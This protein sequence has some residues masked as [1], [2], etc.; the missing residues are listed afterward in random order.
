M[1]IIQ[2]KI[3]NTIKRCKNETNKNCSFSNSV[4]FKSAPTT[5]IL[6]VAKGTLYTQADKKILDIFS[7]YYDDV[8]ERLGTKVYGLAK[9]SKILSKS[10]R[11]DISKGALS[12]KDK[13]IGRAFVESVVFPFITLP[14]Y[15]GSWVLKKVQS[16]PGL[17]TKARSIYNK[18][19]LRVPRKYNELDSKTDMIK[20]IFD[21]TQQVINKYAKEKGLSTETVL[22][23]LGDNP[24]DKK[25]AQE[26]RDYLRESLYKVSN[27]FF[28][29]RTGNYNTAHERS[30]N[31]IVSGLIPAAF[32]ANDAYNLSVLCGDKKEA[33]DKEAKDRKNQE[34]A[35]VLT[36]AYIQLV[37]FGAFVKQVNTK[38]WFVPLASALTVLG[39]EIFSRKK[40]KKPIFFLSKEKAK[41][42]N[43]KHNNIDA[44]SKSNNNKTSNKL[45]A[46]NT[47]SQIVKQENNVATKKL[48]KQ[49]EKNTIFSSFKSNPQN[50]KESKTDKSQTQI[51]KDEP[52]K[53]LLNFKTFKNAVLTCLATGF[54]VSFLKNSS[55]TKNSKLVQGVGNIG[56]FFKEKVYSPLAFKDFEIPQQKYNNVMGIL[57]QSNCEKISQGHDF[58]MHKYGAV[59]DK[60]GSDG[61]VNKVIKMFQG[62]LSKEKAKEISNLS[63]QQLKDFG[64]NLSDSDASKVMESILAAVSK[65]K[66]ALSEYKYDKVAQK[67]L[68]LISRKKVPLDSDTS[69]KFVENLVKSLENNVQK[70]AIKVDR[71]SKPFVDILT[72]PFKFV[73]SAVRLPYK[74]V[75]SLLRLSVSP[76]EKKLKVSTAGATGAKLT[77]LEKGFYRVVT[78]F[79]GTSK[80]KTGKNSQVVFASAMETLA[81]KLKPYLSKETLTKQDEQKI[82]AYVKIAVEKSFNGVTQSSNKNTELAMM[83]KLVSSA[84]TSGFLVADNYNMVMIKSNGE[85]K[86]GAK[87][88]ANERIVQRLSALFY[89]ALLINWFNGTFNS[90]YHSSLKGMASVVAPNTITTEVLTRKSIGMPIGKKSF[91]EIQE[92]E[93]KN[94]NRKGFLGKYFKFMRLLTG[95]KPLKDRLPKEK[96]QVNSSV[97]N[98]KFKK[99]NTTNLI[100]KFSK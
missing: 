43:R 83:A 100:E 65:E 23:L 52:K 67:A 91:E 2:P 85:D 22:D 30:L 64:V 56:K 36:T 21:K 97:G 15:F 61:S 5:E 45:N 86:E 8:A 24:K 79:I 63:I 31:R 3:N 17:K 47:N 13:N 20:G 32:L 6:N 1:N 60:V 70:T 4:S 39:S 94:E 74:I 33:S 44:N 71:K 68:S 59:V 12:I 34:I 76:I 19:I 78:E 80:E 89:Q 90:Q 27:K 53:A 40:V 62:V 25:M 75:S 9:E 98:A 55:F 95:K 66:V 7:N 46:N 92:I 73:F 81:K 82:A 49:N 35:R 16:I 51:K 54:A 41:E 18:P 87:E 58:I 10:S 57:K 14:L 11:F 77:K 37:M 99:T 29:K 28:D 93:E 38:T 72:E 42:Y 88:K 96:G 69:K 26:A 48:L 50:I 84:V